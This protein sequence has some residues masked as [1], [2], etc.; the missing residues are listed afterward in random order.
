MSKVTRKALNIL[1]IKSNYYIIDS[2]GRIFN[3][4]GLQLKPFI[5][6][7]G[8]LRVTL[9]LGDGKQKKFSLHRLVALMFVPND[10]PENKI[11]VNHIDGN[12]L[13][14]EAENLEW[15]SQSEN[16]LHAYDTGLCSAKGTKS[17]FANPERYSDAVVHKICML[18][19]DYYSI[20]EIITNLKL[21][22]QPIDRQSR[23]YQRWRSY[24]KQIR[25]RS[26][27]RDITSQYDF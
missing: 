10:D 17:H 2:K 15:V 16:V 7:R 13:N 3:P 24:I 19:E 11:H 23:E 27:R 22:D 1:G 4:D 8:Y 21:M 26:C 20:Y 6:N 5:S 25:N 14:C 18:L 12:P 9:A